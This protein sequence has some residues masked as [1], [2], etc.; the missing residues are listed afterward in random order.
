MR[1]RRILLAVLLSAWLLPAAFA[2]EGLRATQ[3]DLFKPVALEAGKPKFEIPS[4]SSLAR[5]EHP[6][7]L[8][9]KEDLET[10]RRRLADPRAFQ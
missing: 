8:L 4:D 1:A 9:A 7:F 5:N 2:A 10:L 3:P 6:R